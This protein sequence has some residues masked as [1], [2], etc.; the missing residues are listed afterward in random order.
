MPLYAAAAVTPCVIRATHYMRDLPR[1][2][3]HERRARDAA[4]AAMLRIIFV[5]MMRKGRRCVDMPLYAHTLR[6][7]RSACG[8]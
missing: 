2:A 6:A 7:M 4:Y 1:A 8:D 5:F 3:R